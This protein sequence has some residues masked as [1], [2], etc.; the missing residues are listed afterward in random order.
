MPA[1][2]EFTQAVREVVDEFRLGAKR[3]L[4]R[5]PKPK[6][7]MEEVGRGRKRNDRVSQHYRDSNI[8]RHYLNGGQ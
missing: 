4:K 1:Q 7:F 3:G 5:R 6:Q 8:S 2:N